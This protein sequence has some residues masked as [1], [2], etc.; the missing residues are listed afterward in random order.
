VQNIHGPIDTAVIYNLM[1][2]I[3]RKK[4][5][6]FQMNIDR[7]SYFYHKQDI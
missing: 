7:A 2:V 1:L 3:Y 6:C 4:Q 5:K